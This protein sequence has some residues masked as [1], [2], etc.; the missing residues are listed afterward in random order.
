MAV[1]FAPSPTGPFHLGNLRSAWISWRWAQHLGQK[2]VLRFEDIDLSRA[3]PEFRLQ[4]LQ[5]M[6]DFGLKAD[7]IYGQRDRGD[8]HSRVFLRA[9]AEE[10]LYPCLCSRQ[11]VAASLMASA[12]HG[13]IAIY[14]GRCRR[15]G[16]EQVARI[17]KGSRSPGGV[18][19]RF[20]SGRSLEGQHDFIVGRSES[21][22]PGEG[23][24]QPAYLWACALDDAKG[25]Y[26]L[27]VRAWDLKGV[28][29]AQ[30]ELFEMLAEMGETEGLYVPAIFHTALV[31]DREGRRLEKRSKDYLAA[32]YFAKKPRSEMAKA[33]I[34]SFDEKLLEQYS[35]GKIFGEK[36]ETISV[37]EW[38]L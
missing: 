23:D 24:F 21:L 36:D 15:L 16:A 19:W 2:W 30:A 4:Q 10:R 14:S 25:A 9:L 35:Q 38:G 28:I 26:E 32:E 20:R 22:A 27:L 5:E 3:R 34:D 6:E 13:P 12:P 1:R 8:Y 33:F 18:A 31:T 7:V 37:K 17:E 11:E 29:E